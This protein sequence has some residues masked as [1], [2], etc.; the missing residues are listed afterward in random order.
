MGLPSSPAARRSPDRGVA[1][2]PG[3]AQICALT[4]CHLEPPRQGFLAELR[5]EIPDVLVV[6]DGKAPD[7]EG[8]LTAVAKRAGVHV[9][10]LEQ[11]RGKGYAL[12]AG[13]DHLLERESPPAAV[14]VIDGDGQH[15]PAAIPRFLAAEPGAELVIGDRFND[16]ERMPQHRRVANRAASWLL[17]RT[18]GSLVLDSQCGMRL[19]RGRALVGVQFPSG[20]YEAETLHL[21]RCLEAGVHVAWVPVPAIYDGQPS[22]FRHFRDS[23]RV[24][25]AIY[26]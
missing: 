16:P 5:N 22:S 19:L 17:S 23:L 3:G 1:E 15:S 10:T 7:T 25:A 13:I 9:L 2:A 8:A 24:L 20:G 21:R 4:T 12:S 11:N 18:T 6:S 26:R 14:L